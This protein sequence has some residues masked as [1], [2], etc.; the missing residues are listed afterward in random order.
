MMSEKWNIQGSR[1]YGDGK[2]FNLNNRITATQLQATLNQYEQTIQHYKEIQTE[3]NEIEAKLD[4]IQKTIIQL[5]L[6]AGIMTEELQKLHKEV[7]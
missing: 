6:T 3:H 2:S 4:R 1:V 7:I 5:Q